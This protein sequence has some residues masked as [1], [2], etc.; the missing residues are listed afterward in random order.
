MPP[1]LQAD[2]TAADLGDVVSN[3]EMVPEKQVMLRPG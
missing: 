1:H 3:V 2:L